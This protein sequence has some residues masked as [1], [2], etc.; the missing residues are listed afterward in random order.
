MG[1]TGGFG[2]SVI[3]SF[4]ALVDGLAAQL[5][6]I[7]GA[8]ALI[9]AG[10][11]IA[12]GLRALTRRF[13]TS[14]DHVV[15]TVGLGR[16]FGEAHIPQSAAAIG[17][18]AVFWVVILFFVTAATNVLGLGLF[19]NWLDRVVNFLPELLSGVIIFIAA[20]VLGGLARR[21]T[22]ALASSLPDEQRAT[23]GRVAQILTI[24]VLGMVGLD[25]IG[26]DVAIANTILAIAIAAFLGGLSLAFGFG[27]RGLVANLMGVRYLGKEL[28]PG[29][30]IQ[31]G[32]RQG[33]IVDVTSTY[34]VLE[35]GRGRL[36]L[37]G[38]LFDEEGVLVLNM[39]GGPHG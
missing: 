36:R 23:L 26:I 13:I 25:Q 4:T 3:N 15:R 20:V 16:P 2:A 10:W 34:I 6:Q 18:T 14:L 30:E 24:V 5:P 35:T 28:K 39:T 33:R 32:N 9:V 8:I 19:T 31:V 27:A 11:L 7:L 38:K 21:S 37:P 12:R 29:D 1:D 22:V 17:G